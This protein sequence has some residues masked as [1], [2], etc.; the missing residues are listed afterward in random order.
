MPFGRKAFGRQAFRRRTDIWRIS[1]IWLTY[2][3][4]AKGRHL[5]KIQTFGRNTNVPKTDVCPI[6][7]WPKVDNWSTADIL[8]TTDIWLKYTHLVKGRHLADR[9]TFGR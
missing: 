3:H 2:K 9:Q 6:E 5:A 1:D 7:I 4:L 8:P